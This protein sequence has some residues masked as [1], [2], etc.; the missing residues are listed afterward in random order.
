[1]DTE[2]RHVIRFLEAAAECND[3]LIALAQSFQFKPEVIRVLNSF[4]CRQYRTGPVLEGY[5]DIELRNNQ[6]LAWWLE[7]HWNSNQ[8]IIKS[9]VTVNHA[10]GQD[11]IREF[12]DR[13]ADTLD[14]CIDQLVRATSE[15]VG[16]AGSIKLVP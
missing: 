6:A 8:W 9:R 11:V 13:E 7:V 2:S 16:S 10:E 5:V 12:S 1:M 3:K 14:E 15:L 4:E